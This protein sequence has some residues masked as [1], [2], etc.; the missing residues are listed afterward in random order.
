MNLMRLQKVDEILRKMP[1]KRKNKNTILEELR[2]E[3]KSTNRVNIKSISRSQSLQRNK[4]ES[5]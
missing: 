5:V 2:L 1:R 3:P 4:V